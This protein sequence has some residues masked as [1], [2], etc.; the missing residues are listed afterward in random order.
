MNRQQMTA[1]WTHEFGTREWVDEA[2]LRVE[3]AHMAYVQ[4]T[5]EF[6]TADVEHAGA[7]LQRLRSLDGGIVEAAAIR[8]AI[9]RVVERL[10]TSITFW[11]VPLGCHV[12]DILGTS[13]RR[14]R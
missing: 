8:E 7:A 11:N 10:P 5:T 14:T 4:A 2:R 13:E 12:E 9:V 6:L 1:P 3:Q